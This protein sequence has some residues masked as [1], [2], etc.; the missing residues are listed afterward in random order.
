MVGNS[1]GNIIVNSGRWSCEKAV[2][3]NTVKCIV[4]KRLVHSVVVVEGFR[5]KRSD[6]TIQE[7][8]LSTD[9]SNG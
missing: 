8:G 6:G 1:D 9:R 3:A 5:C 7:A 2:Q 4:F